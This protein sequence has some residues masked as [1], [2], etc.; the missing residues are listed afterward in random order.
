MYNKSDAAKDIIKSGQVDLDTLDQFK[1]P[2]LKTCVFKNNM[3]IAELLIA[4]GCNMDLQDAYGHTALHDCVFRSCPEIA[5][6][7]IANGCDM[8]VQN[9]RG[10]TAERLIP[11]LLA[12]FRQAFDLADLARELNLDRRQALQ[13]QHRVKALRGGLHAGIKCRGVADQRRHRFTHERDEFDHLPAPRGFG[14]F[15]PGQ[16][17]SAGLEA[18][19]AQRGQTRGGARG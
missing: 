11:V 16:K 18:C 19:E 4:I 17:L 2:L 9:A 1:D 3:E 6:L 12:L 14:G 5:E 8:N 15:M 7:L 10:E 13:L